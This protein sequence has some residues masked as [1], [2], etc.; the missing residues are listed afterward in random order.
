MSYQL[1]SVPAQQLF[2]LL[3]F[4]H[5]DNITEGLFRRAAINAQTYR[6]FIPPSNAEVEV[7][8]YVKNL[9][10]GYLD[11]AGSWNSDA[12]SVVM[13]ELLSYSLVRY[14]RFNGTYNLQVLVHDWA[15]TIVPHPLGVGIEHTMFLLALSIGYNDSWGDHVFR[16]ALGVHVDKLLTL[17]KPCSN[18]AAMFAKVYYH[19]GRWSAESLMELQVLNARR[20]A[21]G[22]EHPYTLSIMHDLACTYQKQGR[23]DQAEALHVQALDARK[24]MLGDEHLDTMSALDSL[25]LTY[26]SQGRFQRAERFHS[27]VLKVRRERLGD[28]HPDTLACINSL[29]LTYRCLLRY[30][31]AVESLKQ[32]LEGY[33]EVLGLNHPKTLTC[34][35]SLALTYQNQNLFVEAEALQEQVL[36]AR[37]Q[38][39]GE[40][41]PDTLIGM[42]NLA[43]TY[44]RQGQYRK[45]EALRVTVLQL[46]KR[47]LGEEHPET[48]SCIHHLAVTYHSLTQYEQAEKLL[49]QVVEVYKRIL[50]QEHP[51]TLSSMGSLALTYRGQ[52][53]RAAADSLE[54]EVE[55]MRKKLLDRESMVLPR[56]RQ[57]TEEENQL[58][59]K[60]TKVEIGQK[61]PMSEIIKHLTAHGCPNVTPALDIPFCKGSPTSIG[62]F[63][64]IYEG[65]MI[66]GTERVAIK[67]L[68]LGKNVKIHKRTAQELYSWSKLRDNNVL[69]LL[70]LALF[71]GQI[72][73]ISPWIAHG[74]LIEYTERNPDADRFQLCTGVSDG[75][76]YMH[77]QHVLHGDLKGENVLISDAGVP[78]L[79][80]FGCSTLKSSVTIGFTPT[81]PR[82][83]PRW[84][85]PELLMDDPDDDD[86]EDS[87][88][89]EDPRSVASDVYALGMTILEVLTGRPP[90]H[91]KRDG[92]IIHW[93]VMARKLPNRPEDKIPSGNELADSLWQMLIRSWSF[94]R[95]QRPTVAE[96]R[97]LVSS[98][99]GKSLQV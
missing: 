46:M 92:V 9:L 22:E 43:Y 97:D 72:A 99:A 58:S 10:E 26:R 85:A 59:C 38:V 48:L 18:N 25:A 71:R 33:K 77:S 35:D 67:C 76:A 17:S 94:D 91:Y 16:R 24:R 5:H 73:M 20:Q 80:D 78:K 4:L 52:G 19:M 89:V 61:T 21:L 62:G 44:Q 56:T 60:H 3:A 86:A 50:G 88:D 81:S 41:H 95:T 47:V 68:R 55:N 13:A 40:G 79:V 74:N 15:R 8:A 90:Y 2:W 42:S 53:R 30:D 34:M 39:I 70:G 11:S 29:A 96:I 14:D 65:R 69:Q 6:F 31:Q 36:S 63:S 54:A 49:V 45:S 84:A 28:N 32:V 93:V 7:H 57:Q 27:Q 82:Y 23:Y 37:R 75:L 66:G 51:D 83:T 1:L 87:L 12:F 98:L 64:D